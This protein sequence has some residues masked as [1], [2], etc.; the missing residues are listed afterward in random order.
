MRRLTES[1]ES[2]ISHPPS[3]WGEWTRV[4]LGLVLVGAGSLGVLGLAYWLVVHP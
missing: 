3:G 1:L 4:L 2:E